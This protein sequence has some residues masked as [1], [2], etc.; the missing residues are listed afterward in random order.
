MKLSPNPCKSNLS[1]KYSLKASSNIEIS[2]YSESGQYL[3]TLLNKFE[4]VD[5]YDFIWDISS[6]NGS[7]VLSGIYILKL[8]IGDKSISQKVILMD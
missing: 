2:I 1:I 6:I 7:P 4:N 8:K 5:E 3:G